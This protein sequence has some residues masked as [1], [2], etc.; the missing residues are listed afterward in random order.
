MDNLPFEMI[1]YIYFYLIFKD[2]LNF[3]FVRKE[4]YLSFNPNL[5]PVDKK[6]LLN[7]R[8]SRIK[9][10]SKIC[11]LKLIL[12]LDINKN[13]KKSIKV[14]DNI[15]TINICKLVNF[16]NI[17]LSHKWSDTHCHCFNINDK[18]YNVIGQIKVYPHRINEPL[19]FGDGDSKGRPENV[20][21]I[22]SKLLGQFA[23]D[24]NIQHFIL[25]KSIFFS[26]IKRFIKIPQ[27]KIVSQYAYLYKH[28]ISEYRASHYQKIGSL[29]IYENIKN[30]LMDYINTNHKKMSLMTWKIIIF[31]ILYT[32]T[33]IHKKYPNFKH[34]N[35]MVNKIMLNNIKHDLNS[36]NN[37]ASHYQYELNKNIFR[38]PIINLEIRIGDFYFASIDGKV[39]NNLV[40][41]DWAMNLGITKKKNQ[42]YDIHFL[43]NTILN[44]NFIPNL[45]E[46]IPKEIKKFIYRII[47]KKYRIG[48]KN[49][50]QK[51]RLLKNIEYIT[52]LE[53]LMKD[54]LFQKFRTIIKN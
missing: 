2:R 25:P 1:E 20:E 37:T 40:N 11:Q 26:D 35:L 50:S 9:K 5:Y 21:F 4:Y 34:N 23:L 53:I 29:L 32:L 14:F 8:I 15:K 7:L 24:N 10:F 30:N 47:P 17:K 45:K 39:E 54:K 27:E 16:M 18:Y 33:K 12:N 52:P 46:K 44:K 36:I 31:Q 28:F 3:S 51:G 48:N 43:F 13:N 41:S 6:N 38:I 19:I 49:S 42:Y 22:M